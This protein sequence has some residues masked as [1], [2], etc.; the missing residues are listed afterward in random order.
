MDPIP[1][2]AKVAI[3]RRWLFG[4]ALGNEK[5]PIVARRRIIA[6]DVEFQNLLSKRLVRS[7]YLF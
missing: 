3:V 7:K 6:L 4:L 1:M 5:Y 2:R